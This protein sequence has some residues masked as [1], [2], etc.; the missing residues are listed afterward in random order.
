MRKGRGAAAAAPSASPGRAAGSASSDPRLWALQR[1]LTSMLTSMPMAPMGQ[2]AAVQ[3]RMTS[4]PA[5]PAPCAP[6]R[7]P[8]ALGCLLMRS[9]KIRRWRRRMWGRSRQLQQRRLEGR[10]Q[11]VGS[12]HPQPAPPSASAQH[13]SL[14]LR[15][16]QRSLRHQ[17]RSSIIQA[18]G[19]SASR[20]RRRRQ[21]LLR[22]RPP[23]TR[24]LAHVPAWQCN[25]TSAVL[26]WHQ[27][28]PTRKRSSS[29]LLCPAAPPQRLS[30][31][32]PRP[33]ALGVLVVLSGGWWACRL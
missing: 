3:R 33:A 31:R 14:P 11:K 15:Q 20:Q 24:H 12:Q 30:L 21:G 23:L 4:A 6:Q 25:S 7:L 18:Q 5:A 19:C 17:P 29:S 9:R 8:A 13:P 28:T 10:W 27:Q 32:M 2:R 26:T 1:W 22:C 16:R